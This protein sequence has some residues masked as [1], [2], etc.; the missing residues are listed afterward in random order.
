METLTYRRV[1]TSEDGCG[2]AISNAISIS[3]KENDFDLNKVANAILPHSNSL[4]NKTWGVKNMHYT[5]KVSLTVFDAKGKT[6]FTTDDPAQEW[7]GTF[8]G[9]LVPAG[10]YY[11]SI[12]NGDKQF[13]GPL[14]VI[15]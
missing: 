10:T 15:Y 4:L 6:I 7:D 1:A 14:K 12:D 13:N 2:T 11:F 5:G 3:V 9:D 8:N